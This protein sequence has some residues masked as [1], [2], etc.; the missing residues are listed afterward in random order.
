VL[1]ELRELGFTPETIVLLPLVP[2]IEVAWAEGG[3]TDAERAAIE[4]VAR[5]RGISEGSAAWQQLDGWLTA[6]P[7]PAV[8]AGAGR[9]IAA[10]LDAGAVQTRDLSGEDLVRY[11]ERIAAASGGIFGLTLRSVSPDE[12]VILSRVAA[13]LTGRRG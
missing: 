10:M 3:V 7:S 11:C 1:Q 5:Q 12:R 6:R 2:L 4:D 13:Q 9:L 8:L